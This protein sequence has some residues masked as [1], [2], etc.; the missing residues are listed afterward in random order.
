MKKT[1]GIILVLLLCLGI[2]GCSTSNK[3]EESENGGLKTNTEVND[4]FKKAKYELNCND[5]YEGG[6]D[7]FVKN[8]DSG[9]VFIIYGSYENWGLLYQFDGTVITVKDK[10]VVIGEGEKDTIYA[11]YE[12]TIKELKLSE[13]EI[14]SYLKNEKKLYEDNVKDE[15]KNHKHYKAGTYE[16]G[17]DIN[18]GE[19][20]IIAS[21]KVS[22]ASVELASTSYDSSD[23]EIY[24]SEYTF[25]SCYV[26]VKN[27][28]YL[29]V[30]KANIFSIDDRPTL[31]LNNNG[32]YKVG[33]D[34]EPGIYNIHPRSE[35]SYYEIMI[36]NEEND[37]DIGA[38]D[39]GFTDDIQIKVKDGEYLKLTDVV[40]SKV[41]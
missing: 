7:V 21:D 26:T 14:I 20:L 27:G 8:H 22:E 17:K 3:K 32:V 25:K 38:N 40:I 4:I 36:R 16:V 33:V 10:Q 35:S 12:K 19:Y 6:V 1:L 13:K 30:K 41:E 28:Q 15:L 29:K 31:N 5:D 34:L 2:V 23:T 11:D 37:Y 18:E 39:Y 9:R 24:Y